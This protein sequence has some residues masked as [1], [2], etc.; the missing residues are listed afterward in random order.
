MIKSN[1]AAPN[2]LTPNI[3]L[4]TANTLNKEWKIIRKSVGLILQ[5]EAKIS[6]MPRKYVDDSKDNNK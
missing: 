5:S 6:N 4:L 2:F 3:L 1:S